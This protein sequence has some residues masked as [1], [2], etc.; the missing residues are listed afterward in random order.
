[1]RDA[2]GERDAIARRE[3]WSCPG[4]FRKLDGFIN[5]LF[6]AVGGPRT[7]ARDLA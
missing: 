3:Q 7:P 4:F 6:S 5:E 2:A 1:M